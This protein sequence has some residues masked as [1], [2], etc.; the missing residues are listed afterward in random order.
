MTKTAVR[1]VASDGYD[2]G[3]GVDCVDGFYGRDYGENGYGYDCLG[4]GYG[5]GGV[6]DVYR[7]G[8]VCLIDRVSASAS[9]IENRVFDGKRE[10]R[11]QATA[12]CKTR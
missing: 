11:G 9:E 8:G 2:H 3:H 5:G 6:C 12:W 10:R 7:S 4:G 1:S